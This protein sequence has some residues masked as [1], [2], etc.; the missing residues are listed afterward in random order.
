[1]ARPSLSTVFTAD[2]H[3][4]PVIKNLGAQMDKFGQKVQATSSLTSKGFG[5][6]KSAIIGYG[7]VSAIKSIVN[8]ASEMQNAK[9]NFE[10]LTGSMER[11]EAIVQRLKK[12]GASTPFEFSDLSTST[13][14]LMQFGLQTDQAIDSL[15]MLG[16]VAM[17]D[18]NK[19]A[20][21]SVV[22]GQVASAGKLQGQDLMQF[23]NQGF[24]PLQELSKQTGKTM[25]QLR[26]E[27]SKGKITFDMVNQAFVGA[28]SAGGQFFKGMEKGS[29]TFSGKWSTM[30]DAITSAGEKI[31]TK[32][33]PH[34][35]KLVLLATAAASAIEA[36]M[37]QNDELIS[38]SLDTFINSI[39]AALSL[40]VDLWNSGVIP[41]LLVGVGTFKA[42]SFGI[43]AYNTA[44]MVARAGTYQFMLA[45]LATNAAFLA[46]P[47]GA[48]IA[49]VIALVAAGYL[50]YRNFEK[51]WNWL[52]SLS[53]GM[54]IFAAI[55]AVVFWPI[56]SP[57]LAMAA[58][59]YA[60]VKAYQWAKSK[61]SGKP[62]VPDQN[63]PDPSKIPMSVPSTQTP[64]FTPPSG[65]QSSPSGMSSFTPPNI[66]ASTFSS[67]S[68]P[69]GVQSAPTVA[70][71]QVVIDF[72]NMPDWVKVDAKNKAPNITINTGFQAVRP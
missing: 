4:T 15:S 13:K 29:Q 62:I 59:I 16:D 40:F 14:V 35:E 71:T 21:L 30:M 45:W 2:D 52:K 48:V 63:I 26:D 70:K 43:Y 41:T 10:V 57:I 49:G 6:L 55:M 50:L 27:M 61:I 33:L 17:G 56:L 20:G 37:E 7:A 39:S 3:V 69:G 42:I 38:T 11:S 8:A 51:I 58:G 19:L 31:G 47:I 24:N 68:T 66:P 1:M 67:G 9:T 44:M 53:T 65:M 18:K 64:G 36:W 5:L 32:L 25:S 54:K 72:S 22:F 23:I 12:L 34:I 46:T 60:L 28:T